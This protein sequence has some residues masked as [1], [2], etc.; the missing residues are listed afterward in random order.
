MPSFRALRRAVALLTAFAFLFAPAARAQTW[1]DRPAHIVLAFSSGG[2][3]DTLTRV[4]ADKLGAM[5]NV[6]VI[7][8]NRPGG[9]GN[10]GASFA[11]HAAP[12]GYT[13]FMSGQSMSANATIAPTTLFDPAKDFEPIVFIAWAQDVLTVGKNAPYKTLKDLLDAAKAAPGKLN[14]GS[15]GIGSSGHL[16]TVQLEDLT[17]V[18]AEHVPYTNFGQLQTDLSAG[19]LSFWL[20]TLGGVLGAVKGGNIRALAVSGEARAKEL[21]D[22]PTFKELGVALV[23]PSTWFGLYAPK[24]TPPAIVAKI[25]ADVNAVLKEPDV[26]DKLA[27]LGFNL[28]GGAP[29]VLAQWLQP[30]IDKWAKIANSPAY[31]Q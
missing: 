25:N 24:R 21:P 13:L 22:T 4:I 18:R 5:W 2:T 16:A 31:S 28:R 10:I 12:D 27:S 17:G 29:D 19:R 23:E 20:V 9:S 26:R 11:A 3:M 8:D 15:L 14:F 7:V 1:P 6:G 30:D